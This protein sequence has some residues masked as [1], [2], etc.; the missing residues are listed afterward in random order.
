MVQASS[1]DRKIDRNTDRLQHT[2]TDTGEQDPAPGATGR[3]ATNS[4]GR[5]MPN[6]PFGMPKISFESRYNSS[7]ATSGLG[8][9]CLWGNTFLT[10]K[11]TGTRLSLFPSRFRLAELIKLKY[12]TSHTLKIR[13]LKEEPFDDL[14]PPHCRKSK[15]DAY[16]FKMLEKRTIEKR[17]SLLIFKNGRAI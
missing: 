14:D 16:T 1:F 10:G 13:E 3:T 11:V 4:H 15:M 9:F 17:C 12:M 2:I 8:L 5:S 6:P 7:E